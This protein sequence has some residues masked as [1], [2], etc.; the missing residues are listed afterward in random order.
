MTDSAG[1]VAAAKRRLLPRAGRLREV[2]LL[3]RSPA[4]RWTLWHHALYY[5]W[6][7]LA[8]AARLHRRTVAARVPLVAIVGS[9][10]KST[11]AACVSTVLGLPPAARPELNG[12]SWVALAALRTRPRQPAQ[13]VEVGIDGP[14]QMARHAR[15]LRPDVVVVTSI[16]SEHNRSLPSLEVAR[17]EKVKMVE[18][19]RRGG[20]AV[21]NGDDPHVR[22]MAGRTQART[23][24][25][26][27]GEGNDPQ[28]CD[29]QVDWPRGT[30]FT[31][32]TAAGERRVRTP[33]LGLPG[34]QAALAAF[35]VARAL[36]RNPD[37]TVAA[38]ERIAPVDGRLC[39]ITL[40]S[41]VV[42][43]CDDKNSSEHSVATGLAALAALP[44]QRRIV[45]IGEIF[46]PRDRAGPLH[47]EIGGQIGRVADLALL[48]VGRKRASPLRAGAAA[49]GMAPSSLHR[50]GDDLRAA[51]AF[52]RSELRRGDVVLIKGRGTQHL[53]RIALALLGH[54]V[55]CML[56]L[57]KVPEMRCGRCPQLTVGSPWQ[58]PP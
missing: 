35:A 4:G 51:G 47:R 7:V 44:A 26:G 33:L 30:A 34:V 36:G 17:G 24:W 28:A 19:L 31:L 13:V 3:L 41:G 11:T 25:F 1:T 29:V 15:M 39:P 50:F 5:A 43:L 49:A 10:G 46:E 53:E 14:G 18:A 20:T 9:L 12:W 45:V 27:L 2:P 42:L 38:L 52:L 58:A 32:R 57:C 54:P 6:P 22:W 21:L 48:M 23:V 56:S 40:P 37:E 16:T 8:T 55:R